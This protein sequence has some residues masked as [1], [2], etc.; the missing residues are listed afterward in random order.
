M[1][2]GLFILRLLSILA[3]VVSAYLLWVSLT[4]AGLPAGWGS[5]SGCASV[6]SS[7]WAGSFGVPVSAAALV[8]YLAAFAATWLASPS[9]SPNRQR[10]AQF[11]LLATAF[12]VALAAVWFVILQVF[13]IRAICLWCMTGHA[14]GMMFA[15]AVLW[16]SRNF[17]LPV[18][19]L[20]A[21]AA[22]A[23]ALFAVLVG[24]Q[25]IVK[26]QPA[27]LQ[28]LP[29]GVNAD[30]GPGRK[31]I[32][33]VLNGRVQLSPHEL[34]VL[35]SADAPHLLVMLFDYCCPHCQSTHG[36]LMKAMEKFGDQFAAIA[37]PMPMDRKCNPHV[38]K[39]EARF[40]HACEL[41]RLAL[42]VWKSDRQSF[43]TFDSWLFDSD[44]PRS[45]EQAA[46]RANELVDAAVLQSALVQPWIDQ[47]IAR[48]IEIYQRSGAQRI[49]VIISPALDT[50]VG[51]PA[52][53]QE[54]FN[55][56]QRELGLASE[57]PVR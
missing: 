39:T 43:A 15:A 41:A 50:I 45:P 52:D 47:H 38:K 44:E 20:R 10:H 46:R 27:R 28:R 11:V 42:A 5:E 8:P 29:A 40:E 36:Y 6:L 24:G 17:Q 56:L 14:L 31:R 32:I 37:L 1:R 9:Q 22:V 18:Q 35:G 16:S 51:E 49:P 3:A 57:P 25:V 53:E 33:Q 26:Y 21:S 55:L 13:I 4:D 12:V 34:P 23:I 54:L 30:T 2:S 7:R 19:A 48:N